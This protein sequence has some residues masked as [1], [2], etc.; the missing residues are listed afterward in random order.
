MISKIPTGLEDVLNIDPGRVGGEPCFNGTRAPLE[1]VVDSLGAGYSIEEILSDFP[2]LKEEHIRA[3][4]QWE[5]SLAR[6][7]I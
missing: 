5:L 4:Q 1:S 2:S 3:V 7:G 6:K